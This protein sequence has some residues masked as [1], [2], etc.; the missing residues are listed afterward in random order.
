[1]LSPLATIILVL[2]T[3]FGAL[4]IYRYIAAGVTRRS[5]AAP[6]LAAQSHDLGN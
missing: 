4:P 5:S 3:L 1:V 6:G 2:L